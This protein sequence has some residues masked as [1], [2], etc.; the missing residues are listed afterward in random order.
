MPKTFIKRGKFKMKKLIIIF[1]ILSLSG[2]GC[3]NWSKKDKQWFAS[4]TLAN[5]ADFYLTYE[6]L[7]D[8][9]YEANPIMSGMDKDNLPFYFLGSEALVYTAAH[10]L[11]PEVRTNYFLIPLTSI[12]VMAVGYNTSVLYQMKFK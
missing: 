12:K 5:S 2:F 1:I 6:I 4:F 10:F 7:D 8:G 9:G 3:A 11:G